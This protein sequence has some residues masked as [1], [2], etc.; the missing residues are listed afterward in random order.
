MVLIT[1][2][3]IVCKIPL[4]VQVLGL[5]ARPSVCATIGYLDNFR[6]VITFGALKFSK[7]YVP[8]N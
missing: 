8:L 5:K 4:H 3:S 6:V 1:S 2:I 7:K